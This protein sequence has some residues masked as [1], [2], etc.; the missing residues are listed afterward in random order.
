MNIEQRVILNSSFGKIGNF[1][2]VKYG[3]TVKDMQWA[4]S[5]MRNPCKHDWVM[6]VLRCVYEMRK[7]K[8]ENN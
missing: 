3:L 2:P 5:M 7:V 1:Q 6:D 8:N 4:Q